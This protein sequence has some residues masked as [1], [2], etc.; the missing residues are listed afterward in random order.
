MLRVLLIIL[1]LVVAILAYA[2]EQP[3]LY[4]L[5]LGLLA[6]S[7]T[8]TTAGM[9]KR[10]ADIP[11][12][13]MKAPEEPVE[14]LSSL[15]IM[16]IK[17][18]SESE[19]VGEVEQS[20]SV[21]SV[22]SESPGDLFDEAAL[23]AS[24]PATE[25]T[26]KARPS[27]SQKKA[28]NDGR[29]KD[30]IG[31]VRT[32][33]PRARIMVAEVAP[34]QD[35]DVLIPALRSL[36]AGLDANTVCLLRQEKSPLRY[37]VEAIVSQNSYA[38]GQGFFAANEPLLAGRGALVPVVY[39]KV[40]ADGFS[41]KKLGYYHEPISVRQVAMVS[42]STKESH[43]SYL[44]VVDTMNDGG[45]ESASVRALLEQYARLFSTLHETAARGELGS[46]EVEASSK[47]RRDIIA[48]EMERA[49]SMSHPL[50]LALVFLNRGEGLDETDSPEIHEM[51]NAFEA[52]LRQVASDGRIEQFGELTYGVFYHGEEEGVA[53]WA[54]HLQTSFV[55]EKGHLQGGVSVGVVMMQSRHEGPDDLRSDATAALQEAFKS[56]ECTIVE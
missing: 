42:V 16:E 26:E 39:P 49:R 9:K 14:E 40:G 44:L 2:L 55:D 50:A 31:E 5:A 22:D 20:D 4:L 8:L 45:L 21:V 56:G 17:P 47:P 53:S 36:R 41:S 10:H 25:M 6:G 43:D 34:G 33:K 11:E 32:R 35:A 52:R 1:S 7:A 51:E 15:G 27:Q 3:M 29:S 30:V 54:S 19:L 28:A 18:K 48:D 23:D 12:S 38:R 46:Q 24:E 13:F 37:H